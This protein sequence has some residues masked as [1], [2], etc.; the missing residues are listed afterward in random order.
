[1]AIAVAILAAL[2][3]SIGL[4]FLGAL[5]AWL[6]LERRWKALLVLT[7]ASA[8]TV[9]LW[10]LWTTFAPEQYAGT[11]YVADMRAIGGRRGVVSLP[12]AGRVFRRLTWYASQGVP[13]TLAMPTI[14]HS[15]VDN[16]VGI[17]V[18]AVGLVAGVWAFL[19]RW[20]I[21][22]FYMLAYALLLMAWPWRTE[23]FVVPAIPLIV[24]AVLVGW[25]RMLEHRP[26]VQRRAVVGLVSVALIIG[27]SVRTERLL[28]ESLPCHTGEWPPE[29]C[30]GAD[31]RSYFEALRHIRQHVPA[32]AVF[33]TAKTGALYIYTGHR[34]ISLYEAVRRDSAAFMPYVRQQGATYVLLATLEMQEPG[35]MAPLLQAN[36]AQLVLERFFPRR[37]YLFRVAPAG[38]TTQADAA[39]AAVAAYR[40]ANASRDF[41]RDR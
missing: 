31:Q 1:M 6:V 20:R 41:Q 14:A 3:R 25:W 12:F 10:M 15:V 30:I 32:D 24:P 40:A 19:R 34:S 36:C 18:I 38:D 5:F 26:G 21:A 16:L 9:G 17:L 23:R 28:A 37:T 35:Q 39:C 4:V 2:T 8:L 27:G 11:S 13:Y 7:I 33:L 22:A 29:Q